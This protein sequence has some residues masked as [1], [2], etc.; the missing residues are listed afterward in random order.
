MIRII[1]QWFKCE[2]PN[3]NAEGDTGYQIVYK[4][5]KIIVCAEC[6]RKIKKKGKPDEV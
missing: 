6:L 4:G 3:C 1:R 2:Y 5:E